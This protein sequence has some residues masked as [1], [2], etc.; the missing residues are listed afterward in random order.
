MCEGIPLSFWLSDVDGT[1]SGDDAGCALNKGERVLLA[2]WLCAVDGTS[3]SDDA[4]CA[5]I[6]NNKDIIINNKIINY[7]MYIDVH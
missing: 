7:Y 3:S 6:C 1:A 2:F 4:G 5:P